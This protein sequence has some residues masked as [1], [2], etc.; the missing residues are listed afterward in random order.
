MDSDADII[1]VF[2]GTND[3]GHGDAPLKAYVDAIREIA[4]CYSLPV[5]GL[6]KTS[7][8]QPNVSI[9]KFNYMPDGLHPN[10][11]GYEILCKK[12]TSF[13]KAL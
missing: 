13:L 1:V 5:L 6:Y 4:E 11:N 2:G 9:L 3:Y 8:I 10:D 7:G 12:I